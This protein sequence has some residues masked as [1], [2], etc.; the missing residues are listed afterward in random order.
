MNKTPPKVSVVMSVYNGSQYLQE[1]IDSILRQT[2]SDFEFIIIDDCS[3]D[4]T[5]QI[6]KKY[7]SQDQRIVLIQ[8][9]VNL[10]LTKSLNKALGIA[11][12]AY[13]ARQD[14]DDVSLPQR[15][16]KLITLLDEQQE[17]ALVSCNI[18]LIDAQGN[19]I[20]K[21]QRSCDTNLV[22]WY[23]LFYN[24]LAGHSQ[25]VFRR[26]SVLAVGGYSESYRYS[27]DYELWCRL[28]RVSKIAILPDVL[29]QQRVH[30]QQISVSKATAQEELT[31]EQI[32][33]NIKQLSGKEISSEEA[34]DLKGFWIGHWWPSCFPDSRR[35]GILHTN[36]I[37][38]SQAF[39]NR[40]TGYTGSQDEMS[41]QLRL[42]IGQ[43]FLDW[44]Q[45]LSI[46]R[47]PLS[48]LRV[49]AYAMAWQPGSV[50]VYWWNDLKTSIG[51]GFSVLNP[52][53]IVQKMT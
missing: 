28:A 43:Q 33:Q 31:L 11:Q 49:S 20:G 53:K 24:R 13:I 47:K 25:V 46:R 30:D 32:K 9:D 7:S 51:R 37:E 34:S 15:L 40:T 38:I 45:A 26:S 18:E 39:V 23:L 44:V 29:L 50:F 19:S 12:G 16:E 41:N 22:G 10:G 48:K 2:F 27:Q 35:A 17:I 5:W 1:A 36:L 8:N 3:T 21:R 4:D 6:L 14:A 42:L 52:K